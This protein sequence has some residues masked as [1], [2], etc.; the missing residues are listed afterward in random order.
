MDSE[1]LKQRQRELE[2]WLFQLME[3]YNSDEKGSKDPMESESYRVFM[4]DRADDPPFGV[5]KAAVGNVGT[6]RQEEGK[7]GEMLVV[8]EKICLDDFELIKVIGKGS[9]GKV[10]LGME[11]L[12]DL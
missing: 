12:L 2:A 6:G 5:E 4:T 11:A 7:D 3:Y 8:S 9:F 1:F 10:R